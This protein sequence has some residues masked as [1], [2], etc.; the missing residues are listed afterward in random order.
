MVKEMEFSGVV[1]HVLEVV[2]IL[3]LVNAS[4]FLANFCLIFLIETFL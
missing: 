4:K 3:F 2:S 1:R